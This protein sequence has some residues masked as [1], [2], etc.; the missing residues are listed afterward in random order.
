MWG[1]IMLGLQKPS[2]ANYESDSFIRYMKYTVIQTGLNGLVTTKTPK[3]IV[4]GYSDSL[5]ENLVSLPVY[6]G[7]DQ[8][9]SPVLSINLSATN[10]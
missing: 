10:P 2:H 8:T 5:I 9:Q 1:D 7:G 6:K 3:Q 4:E